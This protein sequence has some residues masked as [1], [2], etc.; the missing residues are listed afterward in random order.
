MK[1]QNVY[2][3]RIFL[4][5]AIIPITL[6]VIAHV[7]IATAQAAYKELKAFFLFIWQTTDNEIE[8]D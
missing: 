7:I 1:I 5:L 8:D 4:I 6:F 2:L 3:R